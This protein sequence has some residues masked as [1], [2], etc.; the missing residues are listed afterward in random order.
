MLYEIKDE[1][2]TGK[3]DE[4]MYGDTSATGCSF[5]SDGGLDLLGSGQSG[6]SDNGDI[7]EELK[8]LHSA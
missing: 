8:S 2:R 4:H 5:H 1:A 7:L 6:V 3:L